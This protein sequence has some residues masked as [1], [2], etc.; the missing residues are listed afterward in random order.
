MKKKKT[1]L[2]FN[3]IIATVTFQQWIDWKLYDIKIKWL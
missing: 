3:K 2:H 1:V